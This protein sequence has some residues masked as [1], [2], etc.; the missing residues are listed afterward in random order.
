MS[1]ILFLIEVIVFVTLAY[2]AHAND[3]LGADGGHKGFFKMKAVTVVRAKV[4][5][6][7][8]WKRVARRASADTP[9][10]VPARPQPR[11]KRSFRQEP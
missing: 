6:I 3:R 1:G 11:W 4:A 8:K 7:P 5:Q 10:D 9:E 2:W